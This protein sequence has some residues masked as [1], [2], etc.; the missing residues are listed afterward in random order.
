MCAEIFIKLGRSFGNG[1]N[2]MAEFGNQPDPEVFFRGRRSE[3][4]RAPAWDRGPRKA[5][6]IA[7]VVFTLARG[8]IHPSFP[9][10]EKQRCIYSYISMIYGHRKNTNLNCSENCSGLIHCLVA[11][12]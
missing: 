7:S 3:K 12:N 4:S 10:N 11:A 9:L 2:P 6:L 8:V 5:R 1:S